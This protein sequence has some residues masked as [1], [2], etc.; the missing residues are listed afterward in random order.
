MKLPKLP[1][2]RIIILSFVISLLCTGC[3][4]TGTENSLLKK[5]DRIESPDVG[6]IKAINLGD[7]GAFS[8]LAYSGIS[9]VPYSKISGKVGL[10]PG[11]REQIILDPSEVSGGAD[12]I[13]SNDNETFSSD[14]LNNAKADMITAYF[15]AVNISSDKDKIE[16]HDGVLDDKTLFPGVYEWNSSMSINKDFTLQGNDSDIWIFKIKGHLNIGEGVR[17]ILAGGARAENILWQVAGRVVLESEANFSGTILS[18]PS[19]EM[20]NRS[21]LTGRAFCK[22]GFVTLNRAMI[23]NP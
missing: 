18:Q 20:K 1:F 22:N 3:S 11:I 16:I 15:A 21:V 19:I 12:A 8:I 7:A 4:K 13:M 14:L 2:I 10:T 6:K 17:L 5:S 9:S 23:R